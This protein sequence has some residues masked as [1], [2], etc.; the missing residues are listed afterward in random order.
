MGAHGA[1]FDDPEHLLDAFIFPADVLLYC[2][3]ES[4]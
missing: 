2:L 4:K 1:I 3:P